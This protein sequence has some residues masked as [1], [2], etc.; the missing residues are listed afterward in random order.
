MERITWVVLGGTDNVYLPSRKQTRPV[1]KRFGV[2]K[3]TM[4]KKGNL[5]M[6]FMLAASVFLIGQCAFFNVF[7]NAKAAFDTAYSSQC[8]L[9]KNN[10]DSLLNPLPA[11]IQTN[12]DRALEKA[13]KVME[14]YP[15]NKKWHDDAYF[16][17]GKANYYKGDYDKSL[18]NLARLQEEFPSSP[19]IPESF[20]FTARNYVRLGSLDKAE[21]TLAM[22]LEKYPRLNDD[23]EVTLL[24]VE[25]SLGRESKSSALDLMEK[26][27]A[28][29][30][31]PS[32]KIDLFVRTAGLAMSL[33]QYDKAIALLNAC[34]RDKKYPDK[35]FLVDM[36][37]VGCY[38]GKDS[39]RTALLLT[40]QMLGRKFYGAFI[41][42]ILLKKAS[43][44]SKLNELDEAIAVYTSITEVYAPAPAP[45]PTASSAPPS[46]APGQSPVNYK[47]G[48][49]DASASSPPAAAATAT[50]AASGIASAAGQSA[51]G[52]ALFELG[53]IYQL[54]KGNFVKAKEYFA[55][56]V[57]AAQDTVI[58][59]KATQRVR[60][61]DSLFA[62]RISKDTA[63]ASKG[64]GRKNALDF[65]IGEL[66]W[67]EMDLPDSACA[68][69][70]R[71]A[72]YGDTL[73]P[74][75]L[76]SASYISRS[77]L[78]DTAVSD[79]LYRVLL[80]DYPSNVYTKK[81]Q[82]D[83]GDK[84]TVHT[85]ADS[86]NDAYQSAESLFCYINK[87]EEA[88]AAFKTV[89]ETYPNCETG[90]KALYASAWINDQVLKNNKTAYKLYHTLCDSFPK[91]DLCTTAVKPRLKTVSDTLA[92]RKARGI[93][94][95]FSATTAAATK[96][97]TIAATPALPTPPA[98]TPSPVAQTDSLSD[99]DHAPVQPDTLHHGG[100]APENY[101][102]GRSMRPL[103][104]APPPSQPQPVSA[105]SV[106]PVKE[107]KNSISGDT[108]GHVTNAKAALK[109]EASSATHGKNPIVPPAAPPPTITPP[110]QPIT[111]TEP[112]SVAPEVK[113]E[114]SDSVEV[115]GQPGK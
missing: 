95:R 106:Q 86:A 85:R 47:G 88:S 4:K 112:Q 29:V 70:K 35:L 82:I 74:K 66:F 49:P 105:P 1:R 56:A 91:C 98:H 8:K 109:L 12:Y 104:Q 114:I 34:P 78:K 79:S 16:L 44:L 54:K 100:V 23:Q 96:P 72:V 55:R 15:T 108:V 48:Q 24:L 18:R 41:P 101:R 99:A 76:Y 5:W 13:A 103:P 6:R 69:F 75:A 110:P 83:R 10:P 92:A 71:L 93:K 30:K 52:T 17:M 36:T 45:A 51:A 113:G 33:K 43:I 20:L 87:P 14:E 19:F 37:R 39:L 77:G 26:S 80:K 115:L 63:D 111:P 94:G 102:G 38:E 40:N 31:S 97:K 7:Y 28:K 59:V 68:L 81:A 58:R 27:I 53:M 73:R 21:Q 11:D 62:Y 22:V 42:Y 32:R 25:I 60:S 67:L 90:I 46:S 65:K 89:Y 9:L 3:N 2:M 57:T 61:I 84:I 50:P 64:M 107:V